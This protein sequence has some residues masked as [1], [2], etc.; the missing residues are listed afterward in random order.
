MNSLDYN[1]I[2]RLQEIWKNS[3]LSDASQ[4]IKLSQKLMH[5]VIDNNNIISGVILRSPED[6]LD[7]NVLRDFSRLIDPDVSIT[8]NA[9]TFGWQVNF[10]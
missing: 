3:P 5:L 10:H 9:N 8:K 2:V 1:A 7:F 6:C 4:Y